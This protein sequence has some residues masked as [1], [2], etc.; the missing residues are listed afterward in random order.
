MKCLTCMLKTK[1]YS[2]GR[3]ASVL[4]HRAISPALISHVQLLTFYKIWHVQLVKISTII[5]KSE[6]LTS[7]TEYLSCYWSERMLMRELGVKT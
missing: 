2:S 5:L 6:I 7:D 3:A 4:N 1:F